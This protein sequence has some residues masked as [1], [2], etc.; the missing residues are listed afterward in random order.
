MLSLE[1]ARPFLQHE[2]H[3]TLSHATITDGGLVS[4]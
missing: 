3:I 1:T 2:T 4:T